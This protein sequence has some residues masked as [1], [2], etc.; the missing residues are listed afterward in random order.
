V[1]VV[2]LSADFRLSSLQTYERWYGAHPRPNFMSVAAYDGM[3]AIY[4]VI[5]KLNGVIDGDQAMAAFKGMR[6][7]SPRGDIEVDPDTREMIENV[8][9]RRVDK[10][11]GEIVNKEIL[12]FPKVKA[13]G[14]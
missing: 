14:P 4:A 9:I 13:P 3:A 2:D 12:T 10:L 11:D 6:L 8:Y 7:V 1:R 5:A